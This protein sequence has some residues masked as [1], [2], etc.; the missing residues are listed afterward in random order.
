MI[1]KPKVKDYMHTA[2]KEWY[3]PN[4]SIIH[5]NFLCILTFKSA[6]F[7]NICLLQL[8]V[9]SPVICFLCFWFDNKVWIKEEESMQDEINGKPEQV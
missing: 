8:P 1:Q 9:Q 7:Y 2:R 3:P 6:S 5:Y 4:F